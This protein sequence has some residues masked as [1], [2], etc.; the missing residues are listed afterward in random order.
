[1]GVITSVSQSYHYYQHVIKNYAYIIVLLYT[2]YY[3]YACIENSP[4]TP[5]DSNDS[6]VA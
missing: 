5:E 2:I 3:V 4:M 1:M 6:D